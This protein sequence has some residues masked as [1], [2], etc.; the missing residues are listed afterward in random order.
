MNKQP[1][2]EID[3]EEI[4]EMAQRGEDVSAYFTGQPTAKQRVFVDFPL[5]L[6]QL[7]D[8]ECRV[9]NISRQAWIQRTCAKKVHETCQDHHFQDNALVHSR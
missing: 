1:R 8:A 9:L 5:Q 4:A 3:I 6:L 7:I 2:E